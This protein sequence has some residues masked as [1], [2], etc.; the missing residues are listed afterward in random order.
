VRPAQYY[1]QR[2]GV[3]AHIPAMT[4]PVFRVELRDGEIVIKR[5]A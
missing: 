5:Q 4:N 1:D 2:V 3:F